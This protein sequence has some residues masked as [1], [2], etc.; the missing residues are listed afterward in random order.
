MNLSSSEVNE[1]LPHGLDQSAM[2]KRPGVTQQK[3]RQSLNS[4]IYR[5]GKVTK[6]EN[7]T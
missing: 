2:D 7:Y 3:G 5:P 6:M 1:L 4:G